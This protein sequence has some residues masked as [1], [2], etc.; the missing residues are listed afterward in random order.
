[1][2]TEIVLLSL[3][4]SLLCLD[5][6]FIQA[7]ISRPIVI[8]P[9]IGLILNDPYT[10]LV[11]GAVVELFWIDRLPVGTYIPPN[12]SVVAVLATSVAVLSGQHLGISSSELIALAVMCAIPFGVVAQ[13]LD[14]LVIKSNDAVSDRALKDAQIGDIA[15]IE[16]KVYYSLVKVFLLIFFFLLALMSAL[17]YAIIWIY[18]KLPPPVMGM[19][20]LVFYFLPLLGIAVALTT[21]KMRGAVALFCV[22]FLIVAVALELFYVR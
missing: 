19:L 17:V 12:D 4:G 13:K 16:K 1:M 15:A 20:A 11:I 6:I 22:L 14:V 9:F 5:R 18:P 10:G 2:F 8:S 7:M 21:L 3:C